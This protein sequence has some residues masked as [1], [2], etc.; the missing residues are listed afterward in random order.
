MEMSKKKINPRS[1]DTNAFL[2]ILLYHKQIMDE[3]PDLKE[4]IGETLKYF[5]NDVIQ[6]SDMSEE[7]QKKKYLLS[8][9]LEILRA[10]D[11]LIKNK[12][13]ELV[14]IIEK[15]KENI[16]PLLLCYFDDEKS[17]FITEKINMEK[18]KRLIERIW[19]YRNTDA[20]VDSIKN[21]IKTIGKFDVKP[22]LKDEFFRCFMTMYVTTN[23]S[24]REL[25]RV[26]VPMQIDQNNTTKIDA[27]KNIIEQQYIKKI[28][29][30]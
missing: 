10:L 21:T 14:K 27:I 13:G 20:L 6:I 30:I 8:F 2:L 22:L 11:T 7:L 28:N 4:I 3:I 19:L 16:N 17:L 5:P 15:A 26:Y 9:Y 25:T 23:R 1:S 29:I 18:N 24:I 12:Q